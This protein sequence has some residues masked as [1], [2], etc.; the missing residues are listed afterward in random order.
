MFKEYITVAEWRSHNEIDFAIAGKHLCGKTPGY[1]ESRVKQLFEV[2]QI[3]ELHLRGWHT[4]IKTN[5]ADNDPM[6]DWVD[7]QITFLHTDTDTT[8]LES[9]YIHKM[10]N[11]TPI[12]FREATDIRS[13][14][15]SLVEIT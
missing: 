2:K 13:P 3:A 15:Q 5:Y 4:Q 8:A 7:V 6:C 11:N 9:K 10:L 1:C 12:K 14:R